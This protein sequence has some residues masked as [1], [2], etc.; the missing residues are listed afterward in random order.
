[1]SAMFIFV[2]LD[3][4]LRRCLLVLPAVVSTCHPASN[5]NARLFMNQVTIVAR[6][7]G[8]NGPVQQNFMTKTTC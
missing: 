6:Q 5:Y 4:L 7:C 8:Q 2:G 1:M 3:F